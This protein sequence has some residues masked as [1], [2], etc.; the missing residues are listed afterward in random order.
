MGCYGI[1]VSRLMG[2]LV[3]VHHD[4]KGIMWPES[5][6]PCQ[7]HLIGIMNQESGIKKRVDKVFESLQKAGVE[8]LFD[9]REDVSA[10]EKFRDADLVGIP[11]RLVI[12]EKTQDKIEWKKRDEEKT[13][14]LSIEEVLKRLM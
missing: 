3:E 8:V 7:V 1:G 6:A 12:S 2:G 4:D 5:V 11:V 13:E 10:G 9:D 14:L